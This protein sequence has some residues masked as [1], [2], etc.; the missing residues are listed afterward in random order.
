[1]CGRASAGG[2]IGNHERFFGA[3]DRETA[4]QHALRH[5]YHGFGRP[6]TAGPGW[7]D[8]SAGENPGGRAVEP[9]GLHHLPADAIAVEC[10]EERRVRDRLLQQQQV[11]AVGEPPQVV[12][13]ARALCLVD[14]P[15]EQGKRFVAQRR[16]RFVRRRHGLAQHAC[17]GARLRGIIA[18]AMAGNLRPCR[19]GNATRDRAC[20]DEGSGT[21]E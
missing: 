16:R 2:Q 13:P 5:A 11:H 6:Q 21:F 10:L 20:H 17:F 9:E 12:L 8:A 7:R 4:H 15:A 14:V 3:G 19:H 1:M 18:G